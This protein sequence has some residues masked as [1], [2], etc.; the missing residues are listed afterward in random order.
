MTTKLIEK[1]WGSEILFADCELY[2]GKILH[3]NKGKS[4]HLQHH[5]HKDETMY[6]LTGTG[7]M[8][9]QTHPSYGNFIQIN[10]GETYRIKPGELHKVWARSDLTIIEVSNAIPDSDVVHHD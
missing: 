1:E 2:R 3:I 10:P 8:A 7:W 9:C 4:I 6:V 5:E